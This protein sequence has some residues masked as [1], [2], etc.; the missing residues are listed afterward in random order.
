MRPWWVEEDK[1]AATAIDGQKYRRFDA[2]ADVFGSM[3]SYVGDK[4][5]KEL[6]KHSREH[7]RKLFEADIAGF[8]IQDRALSRAARA[9]WNSPWYFRGFRQQETESVEVK[10]S[11]LSP[12]PKWEGEP[13]EAAALVKQAARYLGAASVGIAKLDRRHIYSKDHGKDGGIDILLPVEEPYEVKGVK[14]VI[15]EKCEYAVALSVQMSMDTLKCVPTGISDAGTHLGYSR[16]AFLIGSLAEFIRGLGYMAIP[17]LN[18]LGASIPIAIYA[19]LGE[20]ARTNRLIT[21]EYGP[22]VR[23]AKVLTDLPMKTDKP[24]R[25]GV[26]EFCGACKRCAESCPAQSLSVK[27]E[28][29]FE[30]KGEW[31]NPGHEG[32]FED[33]PKCFQYW[34]ESTTSCSNC[35]V[36]CPWNKKDKTLVHSVIKASSS[37]FHGLGGALASLDETFGYGKPADPREWWTLNL[38]EYGIDTKQGKG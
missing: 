35:I 29:D 8:R 17:A 7:R 12:R 10:S 25:F 18:D 26:R 16:V 6:N 2:N 19:G 37:T 13:T 9:L 21:P 38:P 5:L 28:P 32:W 14:R 24:I 15:P 36:V 22:A 3:R 4:K 27:D 31:N 34:K 33:S 20:L 30:I 1:R 11:E 23:L